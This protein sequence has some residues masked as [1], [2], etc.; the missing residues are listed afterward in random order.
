MAELRHKRR[1]A[2]G[3]AAV[4]ACAVSAQHIARTEAADP[5]TGPNDDVLLDWWT[6]H[7]RAP[8]EYVLQKCRDHDWVVIGEY[9]RVKHDVEL[10]ARLVPLL[11]SETRVR[12]LAMEFLCED[13]SNGANA[14]VTA[15]KVDRR[16]T[17]DF[18][19]DQFVSWSYEEY[20]DI[21]EAAWRSNQKFA[22]SRGPFRLVGLNPC[23][24]WEVINY[25]DD[26]AAVMYERN[27]QSTYDEF[28]ATALETHLIEKGVP[29]LIY[30]GIAHTTGKFIEY[31]V[32]TDKPLPR[33][34]N[35]VYREPYKSEVFFIALHAPF[36]DAGTNSDIYPFD[37]RLDRLVSEFQRDIGFDI[38]GTP[39]EGLSSKARSA[40]SITA[41]AFGQL[42]DGYI[43]HRTP[44]KEYIGVT[45]IEDW[46]VNEDQFRY[47]RRHLPNPESGRRYS[48]MSLDQF[49]A[50]FCAPCPD[51]GSE[52]KRRCRRLP[53]LH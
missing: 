53:E 32:G 19:R 48:N 43:I 3:F 31:R 29:A 27:K 36:Y 8:A 5:P 22:K 24:D 40:Y 37:G 39:F 2:Y 33:M 13:R 6:R 25:S 15:S 26:A 16:K 35:L 38:T 7:Y 49:R 10:I 20:L 51:H 28:M 52:F 18:F 14:L 23:V 46:I 1:V 47:F 12:D 50:D 34:G 21:F 30:T 9:H 44:M 41:Y 11:H 45:R 42:F 4:V 17:I